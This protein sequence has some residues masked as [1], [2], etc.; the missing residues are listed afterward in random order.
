MIKVCDVSK[1]INQS[2]ILKGV[3]FEVKK[4]SILALIGPNG[5]GKTSL[6]KI[7]T[8]IWK[9]DK[10]FIT[11]NDEQIFENADVKTK[12]GYVP[13]FSHYYDTFKVKEM[14][15]FYRLAYKGFNIS[16][17]EELNRN[18]QLDA[19][20]RVRELSKGN[21]T[22]LSLMLNL[23][24]M[25]EVLILDEPTSGLDPVAKK[26]FL[27]V[28]I[29]DVAERGTTVVVSSHNMVDIEKICDSMVVMDRGNINFNGNLDDLKKK[30]KKL[31]IIFEYGAPEHILKSREICEINKIGSIYY[32]TTR[33][34][35]HEFEEKIKAC[36]ITLMEEIDINLEE[37]CVN[38]FGV[39]GVYENREQSIAL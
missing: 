33:D 24:I 18:F 28:L 15:E 9:T 12:I 26:R 14:I 3:N 6:I 19:K 27:E 22:K 1:K 20:K 32:I 30:V 35:S 13:D 8:G 4:G 21:K 31:Q 38:L 25:P 17:L 29:D 39:E 10:G 11:I 36:G 34:Y 16:R 5:A 37:I 7:L 23:C 2:E